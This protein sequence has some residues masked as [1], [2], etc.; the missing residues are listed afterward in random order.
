MSMSAQES[1]RHQLA[2]L[3]AGLPALEKDPSH[4]AKVILAANIARIEDIKN[5]LGIKH[6]PKKAKPKKAE[7]PK[8][9]KA[10]IAPKG[11]ENL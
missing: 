1:L 8:A 7:K 5:T 11:K 9:P 6:E 10:E 3:L 2:G 4:K